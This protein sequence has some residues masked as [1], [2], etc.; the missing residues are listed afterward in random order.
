MMYP[1]LTLSDDTEITYSEKKTDGS[2]KVYIETPD[3]DGGFYSAT[4][5]LPDYIW[6]N[7]S[8]YSESEISYF[9]QLIR[10]AEYLIMKY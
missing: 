6:E 8:G 7:V 1:F 4:C 3:N 2:V 5:W 10:N 9:K